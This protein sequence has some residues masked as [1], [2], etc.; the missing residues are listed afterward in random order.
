MPQTRSRKGRKFRPLTHR[1]LEIAALH[2]LRRYASSAENLRRVLMRRLAR[3]GL[4]PD[5]PDYR[6]AES[7]IDEIVSR[8]RA[9][10]VLDDAAYAEAQAA[11]LNR[12]GVPVRVIGSR[13]A[14]KGVRA[15]IFD[16]A[17]AALREEIVDVDF[18]AAASLARRRRLGPY[19]MVAERAAAREKDMAALARAG[20]SYEI[21]RRVIDADN[22]ESLE[23]QVLE[24]APASSSR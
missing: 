9:S 10:G 24:A 16:A 2:Y 11:S 14:A 17:L 1:Q 21:A 3:A 19:R 23:G 4:R 5:D 13:L 6:A 15:E 8:L 20:F 12:R 18:K 22:A 7:S